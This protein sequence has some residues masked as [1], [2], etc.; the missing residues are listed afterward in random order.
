LAECVLGLVEPDRIPLISF[1]TSLHPS[2]VRPFRLSLIDGA[3]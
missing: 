2:A 1:T 3:H